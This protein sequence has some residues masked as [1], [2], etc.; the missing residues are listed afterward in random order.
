[1]NDL[2]FTA[3]EWDRL[4]Q[5]SEAGYPREVCGLL[6]GSSMDQVSRVVVLQNILREEHSERLKHLVSRGAVALPQERLGRGGAYEFLIDP[7][8]HF[9]R[10][11]EA[12]KD[13]LDQVGLFHSHPDHP[14]Q[15]SATD[16]AQPFLAGWS[17]IIVAVQGG[18]F[19]EA[20]SWF[21]NSESDPFQEQKILVL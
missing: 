1:M 8:E 3:A 7:E 11:M 9:Q 18:K 16:A 10:I 5:V 6:F 15:P 4:R 21:R 19:K 13:G 2:K 14:A 17:N 12:Q 20:R